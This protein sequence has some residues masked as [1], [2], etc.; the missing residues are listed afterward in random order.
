MSLLSK[1]KKNKDA[2]VNEAKDSLGGFSL[3]DTDVY[4]MII[5]AAFMG[6]AASGAGSVTL[7]LKDKE[8]KGTYRET[9]YVTGRDGNHFYVRDNE[10]YPLMG[11]TMIDD[12]CLLVTGEGLLD[13]DEDSIEEK[14]V[15]LWDADAKAEKNTN[16]EMITSLV[17]EEI[18]VAIEKQIIDKTA[19]GDDNKYHPTGET[20]E[21]N[22]AV[23]VF[24]AE[25]RMTVLEAKAESEEAVFIDKWLDK[26]KGTVIN[27][28]KGAGEGKTAGKASSPQ[29]AKKS[30]F[31]NKNKAGDE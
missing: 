29:K 20:R 30:L 19:K 31:S 7:H 18:L 23:K 21:I 2:K 16:V 4:P 12:I 26:N 1:I 17:G 10:N 8:G 15:K 11:F 3:R 25:E 28:A 27:K 6:E 13:L 14:V 9:F 5:E 24:H 22:A